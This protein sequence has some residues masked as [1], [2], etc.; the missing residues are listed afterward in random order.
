MVPSLTVDRGGHD[1]DKHLPYVLFAYCANEQQSTCESPF[2]LLYGHDPRLPNEAVLSPNKMRLQTDLH[3]YGI[4][5]ACKFSQAW[6]LAQ[7][8]IKKAQKQQKKSYDQH[9]RPPYFLV[10]ES[11]FI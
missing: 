9:A 5:I 2:F 10:G 6:N 11:V 1:W 7:T 8:N 4:Y 3:E